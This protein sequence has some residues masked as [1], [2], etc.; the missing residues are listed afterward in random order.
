[1]IFGL[2]IDKNNVKLEI[3]PPAMHTFLI[4]NLLT[5]RLTI[6]P[7]KCNTPFIKE[8]IHETVDLLESKLDIKGPRRIPNEK[9]IPS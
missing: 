3:I 5:I 7:D 2:N 8:P 4:P 9:A 1:M 6:G